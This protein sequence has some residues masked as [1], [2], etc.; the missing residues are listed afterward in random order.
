[1]CWD[2]RGR[3]MGM[4]SIAATDLARD[5]SRRRA[6]VRAGGCSLSQ[7]S[8][9]TIAP[10]MNIATLLQGMSGAKMQIET[11]LATDTESWTMLS[12][13]ARKLSA[14]LLTAIAAGDVSARAAI[15]PMRSC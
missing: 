11:P 3:H 1:M 5:P 8:I 15:K 4:G 2:V 14:D 12:S 6:S 9:T 7:K 10:C 13:A